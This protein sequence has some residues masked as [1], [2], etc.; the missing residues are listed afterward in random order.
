MKVEIFVHLILNLNR[1]CFE[2]K[3]L[4][5]QKLDLILNVN[6][7]SLKKILNAEEKE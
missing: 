6:N 3:A 4:R 2:V 1:V 5:D 7:F